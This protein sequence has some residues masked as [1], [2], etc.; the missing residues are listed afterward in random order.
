MSQKVD[1]YDSA[2][3]NFEVEV[4]ERVRKKTYGEDFGQSSWTTADEYRG[5]AKWL[6]LGQDSHLLETGSGSGGPA[7]F[8]S[9]LTGCR[10]TGIDINEHG[11]ANGREEAVKHGLGD[12][13]R[14]QKTD[15]DGHLPF[16]DGLFDA[17]ISVDAANHFPHRQDVLKEWFRVLKPG[18]KALF[19]D[20]VVVTGLVTNDE[21]AAR[22]SIGMFVFAPP[23]VN[24]LLINDA[25]F[26]LVAADDVTANAV[27]V[28]GNWYRAREDERDALVGIEGEERFLGLQK[29]LATVHSLTSA[30]RLSRIAYRMRRA[31]L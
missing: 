12:R 5:W 15:A 19:T 28:S 4:L 17:V 11:I 1:L 22:S 25:G 6:E 10:V 3:G 18:G 24:E 16:A 31:S 30:N 8:M 29:F 21:L 14:F 27:L 20:P 26:E 2:Y 13:V 9:K 7:I 23:G